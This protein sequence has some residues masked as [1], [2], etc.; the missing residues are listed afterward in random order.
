MTRNHEDDEYIIALAVLLGAVITER[1]ASKELYDWFSANPRCC[2]NNNIC[3][4]NSR[5][6]SGLCYESTISYVT[7]LSAAKNFLWVIG[8]RLEDEK[9]HSAAPR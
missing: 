2:N 4:Q 8:E 7:Q 9:V 6:H 1:P 3:I 5:K